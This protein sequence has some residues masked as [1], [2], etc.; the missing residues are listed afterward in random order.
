MAEKKI[1]PKAAGSESESKTDSTK[2]ATRVTRKP[3]RHVARKA[4]RHVSR[5]AARK[6]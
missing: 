1:T 3:A 4:A 2:A 6:L 5:K